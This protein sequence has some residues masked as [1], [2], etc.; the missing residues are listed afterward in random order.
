MK[1]LTAA[2]DLGMEGTRVGLLTTSSLPRSRGRRRVLGMGLWLYLPVCILSAW[3]LLPA[4]QA[5]FAAWG[6]RWVHILGLAFGLSFSLTPLCASLAQRF[7]LLDVPDRRKLHARATPLLGG[8]ALVAGFVVSLLANAMLTPELTAILGATLVLFAVGVIDDRRE[9][10]AGVK[11]LIQIGCT[12]LVMASGV[13]LRVLPMH[14]GLVGQIGNILLTVLWIVGITNAMNFFDGMDGLASGLG[15]II[16]FFLGAV[17][18]QTDQAF[19]GWIAVALLGGCLGFLP[20]NLR[21]K[22]PASIFLG[23][24]GSTVI[25]FVLACIAVYGDWAEGRPVVS[26]LSPVL[27]F[28][29]LIFDMVHITIDRVLTGKVLNFRDWIDYVGKDHL[30]HRLA[31]ALGCRRRSVLFI[32]LMS[33]CLGASAFLLRSADAPAALLLIIQASI[34]VVL[35]TV[36]ERRGR[37]IDG[38]R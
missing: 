8:A 22:G 34:L 20:Y 19:L 9:V 37:H 4:T 32:Y 2:Q 14:W 26:L 24:A 28:W 38:G 1:T 15:A 10:P 17:A 11:L 13:G 36:L 6:L 16:A 21:W 5:S 25:G 12:A 23:D 33:L 18:F 30:H 35:I 7:N 3:L 27:M 29:V 31:D